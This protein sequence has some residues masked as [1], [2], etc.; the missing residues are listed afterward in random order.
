MNIT[1]IT[2]GPEPKSFPSLPVNSCLSACPRYCF[3]NHTSIVLSPKRASLNCVLLKLA[4]PICR[5]TL[6][7]SANSIPRSRRQA[8][9][10]VSTQMFKW[11][12]ISS[13]VH[14]FPQ[15]LATFDQL[16]LVGRGPGFF[17]FRDFFNDGHLQICSPT[18][19][20]SRLS[21]AGTMASDDHRIL[22]YLCAPL[23]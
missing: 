6:Q 21:L 5:F 10:K 14:W 4:C 13:W 1:L 7:K 19:Q 3:P 20:A 2:G 23:L 15:S 22:K 16:I 17:L 9:S 11:A 8:L 18:S 12:A